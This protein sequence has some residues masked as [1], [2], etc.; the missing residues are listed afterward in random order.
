MK[1][2]AKMLVALFALAVMAAVMPPVLAEAAS[3]KDIS[4]EIKTVDGTD[5]VVLSSADSSITMEGEDGF[6]LSIKNST[7]SE[8][9]FYVDFVDGAGQKIETHVKDAYGWYC[10]AYS[11]DI[12]SSGWETRIFASLGITY[13]S[14]HSYK[15]IDTF[16]FWFNQAGYAVAPKTL[17]ITTSA[18]MA[19]GNVYLT[20]KFANLWYDSSINVSESTITKLETDGSFKLDVNR[21]EDDTLYYESDNTSIVSVSA[22]GTVTIKGPGI[23]HI[24]VYG[25]QTD[26]VPAA[27]SQTITINVIGVDSDNSTKSAA[28]TKNL[29]DSTAEQVKALAQKQASQAASANQVVYITSSKG[30]ALDASLMNTLKNSPG[31]TLDYTYT[32]L[33]KEYHVVIPG[34][35]NV[36]VNDSIRW[37]G[38]LWLAAHYGVSSKTVTASNGN[39]IIQSGDTLGSIAVRYNTTVANLMRLNPAITDANRISAGATLRTAE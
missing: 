36:I 11:S 6:K 30:D 4:Y 2:F 28:A 25:P 18:V 14:G 10:D 9:T 8:Y 17:D 33:G 32:Y 1:K 37:Y 29:S 24:T 23:A 38:P 12:V 21:P 20:V 31:V 35:K 34:G 5:T 39:Y 16:R 19:D 7:S 26:N 3:D 27:A 15:H 22:D 13:E